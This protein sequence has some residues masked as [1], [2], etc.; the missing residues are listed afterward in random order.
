M[1]RTWSQESLLSSS[2]ITQPS[3]ILRPSLPPE[4]GGITASTKGKPTKHTKNVEGR[5]GREV[6]KHLL[7]TKT[8]VG[9]D[10]LVEGRKDM[11]DNTLCTL[12]LYMNYGFTV[13]ILPPFQPCQ[14]RHDTP[15]LVDPWTVNPSSYDSWPTRL[16]THTH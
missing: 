10:R 11:Q 1:P 16:C 6:C 5:I 12:P 3:A 15:H 14:P 9:R 4:E 7:E 8:V 2:R 13:T